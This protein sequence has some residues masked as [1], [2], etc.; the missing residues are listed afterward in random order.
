MNVDPWQ[1][2]FEVALRAVR[3]GAFLARHIRRHSDDRA[4]LK[5]DQSPVTIADFAVQALVAQRISETFPDDPLVAEE[6]AAALRAPSGRTMVGSVIAALQHV[7]PGLDANRVLDLI[8]RGRTLHGERFWTLDPVDGT[9]GFVRGD[10][11]AVA[12]AL[13]VRGQVAIGLI[14]CPALSLNDELGANIGSIACA[15]RGRGGYY[16]SLQG[17]A[18]TPLRVSSCRDPRSVQVLRSFEAEHIDLTKFTAIIQRLGVRTTPVLMDSQA[19]HVVIAAGRADLLLRVPATKTFRDTIWDQAA[20]SLI[21]EE[22]GGRVS[23]LSGAA[24]DFG[25]GRL[26]TRNEG[27]VA[28]NGLIHPA[29]LDAIRD[30]T[31]EG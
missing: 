14:G 1:R 3:E 29:V 23:D 30:V 15:V 6:D 26:L 12:L 22:A 2:E 21:V 24:L 19:K 18:F 28:S 16:G 7:A 25:T 11:Y 20:G 9:R 8:D 17:A 13:I 27:V 5:R 31:T 10:Q 4:L